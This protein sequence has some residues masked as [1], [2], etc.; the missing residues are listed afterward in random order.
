[1][2]GWCIR[3]NW[4][5]DMDKSKLLDRAASSGEER[6]LLARILDKWEQADRRGAPA[7]TEF[8]SPRER[9]AAETLL[10]L[11]GVPAHRWT[12]SGGYEGAERQIIA[13]LPE[14][15]EPED[16]V[17]PIRCLRAAFRPE[18]ELTHR[19]ILGSLM[20]EGIVREK[21][22]DILVTEG[23]CDIVAAESV[24]DH[25]LMG[26]NT[27]GRAK[28]TVTEIDPA[29]L[30]IPVQRTEQVRDT[31][32]ALRLDAVASSGFRMARGKAAAL[33]ESGRVQVNWQECV[34]PDRLL[35]EGDTVSARG[36]GK[37]RLKEVGGLTKKGRISILLERYV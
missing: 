28:L 32:A 37:F 22:G 20:G 8:L 14:W 30:H 5:T 25:L 24:T 36:V 17:F 7:C 29:H 34:K 15:Q 9:M 11:A 16:A 31:V 10:R 6:L 18:Y 12:A 33:I 3:R 23:C 21:V 35:A 19:D 4:G 2:P 26:W 1:M 13:F 27:A